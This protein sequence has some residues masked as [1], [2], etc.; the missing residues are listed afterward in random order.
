M[1]AGMSPNLAFLACVLP[2]LFSLGCLTVRPSHVWASRA[3]LLLGI[4]F[5]VTAIAA[6]EG[7][8]GWQAPSFIAIGMIPVSLQADSLSAFFLMILGIV[9]A[10]CAVFSPHYLE[11]L[12][13]H[14]SA[15]LYWSAMFA[16]VGGMAGV[17]LSGN[18]VVFLVAWEIMSLSS[19]VLVV[20]EYRKQKAQHAAFIYIVATRIATLFLS[21]GFLLIY[22]RFHDWSFSSWQFAEA[23]TWPAAVCILI[24]LCIKA[25]VWP[26]HVWLPHAHPEAPAP[27]SALMSGV[28]VKVA[29]YTLIRLFVFQKLTCQPLVYGFFI[30]AC[31]SAFW[32]VLFAINQ[33]DLKRLLAYSTVENV[34]LIMVAI[35]LAI[36]AKNVGLD[37][38]AVI[39]VTA[40]LF[41]TFSHAMFKSLLFLCAGSVDYSVHSLNFSA[42][43]GLIKKMPL[44]GGLFVFGSAAICALPPLNGFASKWCIYQ[45][46]FQSAFT[47]SSLFERALCMAAIGALSAVGALAIGCFAKAT[48]VAFLGRARSHEAAKATEVP[49]SMLVPQFL[50]AFLCVGSGLAAPSMVGF[51]QKTMTTT[52][53]AGHSVATIA[54]PI[55]LWQPAA[56][57]S[58]LVVMAYAL[59][60]KKPP[61]KSRTWD[62]GFGDSSI[63]SQVTADS[64]A[65]PIARIFTPVLQHAVTV[66]I[67]GHDRKHFPEKIQVTPSMVSLLE[68]RVYGP[69]VKKLNSFSHLIAKI[70]GGSIHLYLMYVCIALLVLVFAGTQLW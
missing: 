56:A 39:A 45:A 30:V 51:L 61:S 34:G 66:E 25:G 4:V 40:A 17:L 2:T 55:Q 49:W 33:R 65:Q 63:K 58:A 70:Q 15:R 60:L 22:A 9:S 6:W 12:G 48:G 31:I 52:S 42:L 36:W 10:C 69:A 21:A 8:L 50:L 16:F 18:A 67:T 64:F 41:Q 11:R 23:N 29:V 62:C 32:G 37:T 59:I 57:I 46:L 27:A 14:I 20:S 1:E 24:G 28:M 44:T 38:I 53:L 5:L 7:A 26:F 54:L 68:T 47:M 13:N 35:S 3:F 43:G 19:A